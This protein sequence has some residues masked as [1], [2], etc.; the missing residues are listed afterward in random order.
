MGRKYPEQ[1]DDSDNCG[2]KILCSAIF[3]FIFFIIG[4]VLLPL[5]LGKQEE[6]NSLNPDAEFTVIN[7]D[8]VIVSFEYLGEIQRKCDRNSG[9]TKTTVN[10]RIQL[11]LHQVA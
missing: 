1:G 11:K 10:L 8:C 3:A 6:A 5:G 9:N 2:F 7:S 4:V